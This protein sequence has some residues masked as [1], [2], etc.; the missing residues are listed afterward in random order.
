MARVLVME[1]DRRTSVEIAAALGDYGFDVECAF[2]GRNGLLRATAEKY[3]AIVL[4]R[5]LRGD[6][7]GLGVLATLRTIRTETPVLILSA[8]LA[9]DERVRGLRAA[10]D[11]YLTKPFE[12]VELTARLEV[13]I[14]R[15]SMPQRETTLRV[16]GSEYRPLDA[17]GTARRADR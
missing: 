4:D 2:N 14:R 8:L 7:D 9:V 16:G 3:D 15:H 6:L 17:R 11:D 12:A 10:G 13:L 1:D 5:M